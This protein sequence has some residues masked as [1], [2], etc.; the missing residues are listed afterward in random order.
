MPLAAKLYQARAKRKKAVLGFTDTIA[1]IEAT[2]IIPKWPI[3]VISLFLIILIII[4]TVRIKPSGP[5][6][7][8][9][10]RKLKVDV[11][12]LVSSKIPDVTLLWKNREIFL[13]IPK[14]EAI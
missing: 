8:S 1:T 7:S 12:D 13:S 14:S 6:S 3:A 5:K 2:K 10:N 9:R 11:K 4:E